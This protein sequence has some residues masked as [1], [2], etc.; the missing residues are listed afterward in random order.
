MNLNGVPHS[1]TAEA[2]PDALFVWVP[3]CAGTSIYSLLRQHGCPAGRWDNPFDPFENRGF[4]TFGHVDVC[5]LVE[6][7]VIFPDFFDRAFK[8]GFVRNPFD[9]MVS[10][11]F[12]LKRIQC[13]EVPECMDFT[14]FCHK[15]ALGEHSPVGLYNYRGLNQCNPMVDWLTDHSG[16]LIVDDWGRYETIPADFARMARRLGITEPLPHENRG[17]HR[18]YREYYSPE[19]RAIVAEIYR[20]DLE[21]FGYEF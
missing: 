21:F 18:P 10:L 19:T 13:A 17:E 6:V 8:F 20:R 5:A 4:I 1:E 3:K 12:Y 16:R 9:R 11:Y 2:N 15:V 14:G 7:G